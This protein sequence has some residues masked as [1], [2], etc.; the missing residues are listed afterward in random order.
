MFLVFVCIYF[1]FCQFIVAFADDIIED[2]DNLNQKVLNNS[3]SDQFEMEN[4]LHRQL[5]DIVTFHSR[6]TQL[7]CS[8]YNFFVFL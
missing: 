3:E 8:F 2:I 7:S 6:V 1:G 4:E 5:R